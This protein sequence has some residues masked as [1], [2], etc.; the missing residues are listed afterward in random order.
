MDVNVSPGQL[1]NDQIIADLVSVLEETVLAPDRL[2]LE[3][4][5]SG[6]MT[7]PEHMIRMLDDLARTGITF[8]IDDFGTGYSSLA[9]LQQLPVTKIKI[10]KSFV[11]PMATDP[12][13]ASIVRSVIDLAR[14]LDLAVVAE[15]VEDQRTLDHLTAIDCHFVQ[16]YYLSR[17]IPAVELT[18]WMGQREKL[19]QRAG[20]VRPLRTVNG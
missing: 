10:D 14:S 6:I 15:G 18:E 11:I 3:I 12:S 4:T 7:D 1:A 20:A 13:A 16:G 2:V 5:E 19:R 8:A 9:Y 17:P